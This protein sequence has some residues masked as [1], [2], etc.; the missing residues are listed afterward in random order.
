MQDNY[1]RLCE[2]QV[3][4]IAL[5]SALSVLKDADKE[6]S[7]DEDSSD[8]ESFVSATDVS[9]FFFF[10]FYYKR[11]WTLKFC[12][13]VSQGEDDCNQECPF[14]SFNLKLGFLVFVV[15]PYHYNWKE[16]TTVSNILSN[17]ASQHNVKK[18]KKVLLASYE[19]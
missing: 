18:K 14:S 3:E 8:I 11:I 17:C 19:C 6:T 7:F 9:W 13:C 15:S 5:E 2:R 4:N 12:P 10:F 16:T 1:E